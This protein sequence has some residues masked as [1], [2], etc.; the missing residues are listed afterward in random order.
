MVSAR[1]PSRSKRTVGQAGRLTATPYAGRS[2]PRS[3]LRIAGQ[4]GQDGLTAAQRV[5]GA[6]DVVDQV[7]ALAS[8]APDLDPADEPHEELD[9][10][11]DPEVVEGVRLRPGRGETVEDDADEAHRHERGDEAADVDDAGRATQAVR[12]VEGPGQVEADH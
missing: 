8:V 4:P 3:L 11:G 7:Q 1:V 12:G 9:R 5:H 6:G 2:P 10:H